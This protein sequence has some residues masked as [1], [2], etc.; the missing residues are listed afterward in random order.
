MHVDLLSNPQGN[1]KKGPESWA[2]QL[3]IEKFREQL[4]KVRVRQDHLVE[5]SL[6]LEK[7]EKATKMIDGFEEK[8]EGFHFHL[9]VSTTLAERLPLFEQTTIF[10]APY[11]LFS[12]GAHPAGRDRPW[13]KFW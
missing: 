11:G 4:A 12:K 3:A 9:T 10:V 8:V 5:A 7:G 6:V 13:W 1:G 2:R